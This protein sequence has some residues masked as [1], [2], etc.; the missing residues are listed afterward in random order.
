MDG[1]TGEPGLL[2]EFFEEIRFSLELGDTTLVDM[3]LD[4][5]EPEDEDEEVDED[6]SVDESVVIASGG[7]LDQL[8]EQIQ[9]ELE[10]DRSCTSTFL[11]DDDEDECRSLLSDVQIYPATEI[12]AVSTW[13]FNVDETYPNVEN[14]STITAVMVDNDQS[15]EKLVELSPEIPFLVK[16]GLTGSLASDEVKCVINVIILYYLL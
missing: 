4:E 5:D 6:L 16:P 1:D 15:I 3:D 13:H 8:F 9:S 14:I 10:M 11:S 2:D 7:M 12:V